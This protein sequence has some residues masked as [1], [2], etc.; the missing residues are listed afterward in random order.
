MDPDKSLTLYRI[1]QEALNNIIRHAGATLVFVNLVSKDNTILLSVKD[2]GVGF[3]PA[4]ILPN[5]TGKGLLGIVIMQ[6]RVFQVDGE[7]RIE[8]Q[9]DKG[10]HVLVEIP[11]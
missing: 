8:S 10:T 11:L 3:D 2:N 5:A 4:R 7:L 9:I 1:V 6:E